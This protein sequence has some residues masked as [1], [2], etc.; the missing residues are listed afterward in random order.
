M[1][2]GI[3]LVGLFLVVVMLAGCA[4]HIH[5]IGT[6]GSGAKMEQ[7]QWYVLWGLVPINN[8][9]SKV[10]AGSASNYTI[11]TQM[12]PIDVVISFFT[13]IVTVNC[14]TVTVTK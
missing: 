11:K 3:R 14:R 7:R 9:D 5:T 4:T 13:G 1:K 10:M 6:G 12:S 2:H 8:V